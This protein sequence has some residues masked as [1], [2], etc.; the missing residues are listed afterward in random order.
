MESVQKNTEWKMVAEVE[1]SYRNVVK[2]TQR[3]RVTSSKEGYALLLSSWDENR[4]EFVEE[5]K[6]L[7]LNTANK[8]LGIFEV[9]KGGVA[10]TVADPKLIF[11]AALKTNA[12][13][14]ILS[15][16]HPSGNLQPSPQDLS[17]T[18][19]IVEGAKLLDIRIL[20]HLIIT[21]EGYYS[22]SDEG[23]L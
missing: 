10:G 18:K 14:I 13:A 12:S 9:S 23:V 11:M 22:F 15:H 6:I 20:D 5:F 1:L 19:K 21:S 7:L 4:I 3:P 2:P 17:L 16:N 8:V